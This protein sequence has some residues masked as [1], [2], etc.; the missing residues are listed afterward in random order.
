MSWSTWS[1]GLSAARRSA[2]T[3]TALASVAPFSDDPCR[4][5]RWVNVALVERVGESA[6]FVTAACV[7]YEPRSRLL[8]LAVAGHHPAL[9]LASGAELRAQ[10]SGAALGLAREIGCAA[11]GY[12]LADGDG[13]LLYT[14]GLTEARG[15]SGRYGVGRL[16]TIVRESAQLAPHD[17]LELLK[18]DLKEF[19]SDRLT[20]DVCLLVLRSEKA[21]QY[22]PRGE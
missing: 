20:D 9:R 11:S 17:T 5:L 22:N 2:F 3:R 7:T 4:L 6:D 19:A 8:R 15:E 1:A 14:A 12:R 13:V 10:Q 18:R 21:V 16:S